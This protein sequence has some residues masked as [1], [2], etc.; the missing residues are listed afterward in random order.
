MFNSAILDV[1]IGMTFLY[2]LLSLLCSGLKEYI[3]QVLDL[4]GNTLKKGLT[5][6]LDA[7]H[8]KG[9]YENSLINQSGKKNDDPDYIPSRN[10]VLALFTTVLKP[11]GGT[12]P[13]ET[14]GLVEALKASDFGDTKAGKSVSLL[15]QDAGTNL[16]KAKT[17]IE[18]WFNG[19]M[20]KVSAAYQKVANIIIFV[21]AFIVCASFNLDSIQ[22]SEKLL[23]NSTMRNLLV[24]AASNPDQNVVKM[25]SEANQAGN[26]GAEVKNIFQQ[27]EQ[28]NLPLG[29]KQDGAWTCKGMTWGEFF[30]KIIGLLITSF[31]AS[32]GA[33]FWFNLMQKLLN[34]RSALKPQ[35]QETASQ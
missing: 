13:T 3:S 10:F 23:D 4:R 21:I 5:N 8:V 12:L 16:E 2:V 1:A 28:L 24:Q 20:T 17:N 35:K 6:L 19:E 30:I 27:V 32:L 18:D 33:P 34:F 9:L 26:S 31:A 25:I 11:E 14:K 22:I 29:W 7:E 15:I